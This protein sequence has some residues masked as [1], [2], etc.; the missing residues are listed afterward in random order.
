MIFTAVDAAVSPRATIDA[1]SVTPAEFGRRRVS[2][3]NRP[4]LFRPTFGRE[5]REYGRRV[6]EN[7]A[8][9]KVDKILQKLNLILNNLIIE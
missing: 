7:A 8:R 4:P 5:A 9:N 6:I 1:A 3:E 2:G